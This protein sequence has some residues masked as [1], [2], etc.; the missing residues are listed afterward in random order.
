M[1]TAIIPID[2]KRRPIDLI[3]K[4]I[5]LA[6]K[7]QENNVKVI[8]GHNDRNSKYDKLLIKKINKLSSSTI[9]SIE[10]QSEDINTSK[11][12]NIACK[13]VNTDFIMLLDVDIFPDFELFKKYLDRIIKN[14][15]YFY[16][17]PCLYLTKYGTKL[18]IGKKESINS[19]KNKYFNFSRKE[20]L[21]MASPSSITIMKKHDYELAGGFDESFTG[22]GYEDF[23]F[24]I[25]LGSIYKS[26]D[27]PADFLLDKPSRSPLFAVGFRRYIGEL[28]LD[29][30]LEKDMAFHLYHE[31]DNNEKYYQ[32]RLENYKKLANQYKGCL[33]NN[34]PL[35]PTLVTK[36]VSICIKKGLSIHD[37][38]ILFDNKPGHIDRYETF[39]KKMRFLFK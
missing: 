14:E 36:F 33:R 37:Y 8:F 27:T 19:L 3:D 22:H 23:D 31:K 7:A 34:E 21:H 30:L 5:L 39:R 29:I 11:L 16:I 26:I 17:I 18:L 4:A 10:C 35:D 2:L 6:S 20:F 24:L 12:R 25:R 1:L 9:I 13:N 38:S 28:C 15:N 32:A